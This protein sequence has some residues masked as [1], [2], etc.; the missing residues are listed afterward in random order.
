[1]K[2]QELLEAHN[3]YEAIYS[4]VAKKHLGIG[5]KKHH[6][7]QVSPQFK[8]IKGSSSNYYK[9]SA[10]RVEQLKRICFNIGYFSPH[11][12]ES[13]C[14]QAAENMAS[15]CFQH[16]KNGTGKSTQY[17]YLHV[18]YLS[19]YKYIYIYYIIYLLYSLYIYIALPVTNIAPGRRPFQKETHLP[20]PGVSG[21]MLVSGIVYIL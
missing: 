17:Q 2:Q 6:E 9:A 4:H 5:T 12:K 21:A 10:T 14:V 18:Y 3:Q 15:I 13:G 11:G 20:T 16:K 19:L 7:L 1:M 8:T